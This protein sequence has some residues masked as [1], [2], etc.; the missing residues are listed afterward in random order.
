LVLEVV[1]ELA[2]L[3]LLVIWV[4]VSVGGSARVPLFLLMVGQVA[5]ELNTFGISNGSV[6]LVVLPPQ[7]AQVFYVQLV[8]LVL[9]MP[10]SRPPLSGAAIGAY[11]SRRA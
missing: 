3:H 2:P 11:T 10:F 7:V 8:L 6:V 1:P 4:S 5:E 9:L